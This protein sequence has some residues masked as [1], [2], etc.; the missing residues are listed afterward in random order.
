MRLIGALVCLFLTLALVVNSTQGG[1][2][3]KDEKV[4]GFL[5]QYWKNLG[6]SDSQ[7]QK[8]YQTQAAYKA[9]IEDLEMQKLKLKQEE[10]A[11]LIKILTDDQKAALQKLTLGEGK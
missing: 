11:E 10:R 8:V 7:K 9:K 1:G 2:D 3:K 6:L 5:P 4:K